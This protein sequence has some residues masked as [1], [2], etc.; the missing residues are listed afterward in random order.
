VT[1]AIFPSKRPAMI[2]L[3]LTFS[4]HL[5]NTLPAGAV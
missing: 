4:S 3:L 2:S 5:A 1:N